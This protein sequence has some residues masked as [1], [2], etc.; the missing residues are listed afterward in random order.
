M[1]LEHRYEKHVQTNYGK[2]A[3][4]LPHD[5]G[6]IGRK[7]KLGFQSSI[8]PRGIIHEIGRL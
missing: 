8:F 1:N 5:T 2:M 3:T 4:F 7:L 6:G